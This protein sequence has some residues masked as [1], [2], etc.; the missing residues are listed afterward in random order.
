VAD[1]ARGN[2]E[3]RG[4]DREYRAARD[5]AKVGAT[6]CVTCGEAFTEDNPATGGHVKAIRDGGTTADGIEAQCRRCNYG[7]RKGTSV[8]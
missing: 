2:P 4:Y 1:R 3:A 6:H 7:W 5:R 8:S